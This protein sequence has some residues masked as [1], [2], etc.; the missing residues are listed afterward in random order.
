MWRWTL[1]ARR[2]TLAD[3]AGIHRTNQMLTNQ[4]VSKAEQIAERLDFAWRTRTPIAPITETDRIDDVATAYAVQTHWTD[5][6]IARGEKI[7][8]RKIGLTSKAIQQQLS[9]SEPD[10]G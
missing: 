9:V 3:F 5:L 1:S 7:V 2:I 4:S 10:Y 6:R 8:G